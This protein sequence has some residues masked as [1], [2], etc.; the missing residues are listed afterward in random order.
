MDALLGNTPISGAHWTETSTQP[1]REQALL[2]SPEEH[3]LYKSGN[4]NGVEKPPSQ[5]IR[6]GSQGLLVLLYIYNSN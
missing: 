1:K 5:I 3:V 4:G 2:L 6:L